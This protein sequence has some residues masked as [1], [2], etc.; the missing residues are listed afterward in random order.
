MNQLPIFLH[1]DDPIDQ[2]QAHAAVSSAARYRAILDGQSELIS[3][4][5]VDGR[6]T[7]VNEAYAHH[8]G[9]TPAQMIGTNLFD[10]VAESDRAAVQAHLQRVVANGAPAI[11]ENRMTF[12]NG[13]VHWVAWSNGVLLDD[14]GITPLIHSVGRDVTA[15]VQAQEAQ[16]HLTR[17][18]AE[19][20]E[21]LRVTLHS[22]GDAVI[23][24]DQAGL[25]DYMNPIAERLT[26]WRLGE[27]SGQPLEQVFRIVNESSRETVV[28]PVQRCMAENH[29]IGLAN[30][31]VLIARDGQEYGIEDSAAPMRNAE[32]QIIGAVLVFRD[33]TKQRLLAS[34]MRHRATHDALTGLINRTEFEVSLQRMLVE[35]QMQNVEHA[36]LYIDLDQFKLVNDACG[37]A[38]GDRLLRQVSGLLHQCARSRDTL[39]RLGGDEFG[40]ILE[41]CST[42]QAQRVATEVCARVEEFRFAHEGRRF[43]IG[44]SIGL[45]PI[46]ARWQ[47]GAAVLQAA[48]TA[49]YA[50]KEAGRNR[51]HTWF[52]TDK[53][54]QSR[55]GDMQWVRRLE[56]ALDDDQFVL[57]AQRI[58]PLQTAARELHC[59]VLLRLRDASGQLVA[60]GVFLPAAERFH[61]ASRIDRWVVRTVFELMARQRGHLDH[62][63]TLSVNLSGHS[64]GDRS[65]HAYVEELLV[66]TDVEAQRLC[67]EI[68]ET[69]AITN[70]GD[71][72]EFIEAMQRHGVRFALDDFGSGVSSFGSLKTL[73]VDYLK[74]DGQ[75][76][77]GLL[78]DPINQATVRCI[79]EVARAVGKQ[80][81]AEFVDREDE[82]ALLREIG[83]DY[84]QGYLLHRPAPLEQ[85]LGLKVEA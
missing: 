62:L 9:S 77:H 66:S 57:Y 53:A 69:A 43:R 19:Q 76:I 45:V 10:M 55:Q 34:E 70:L 36:L 49:C 59:E 15:R 35:A 47:N 29:T 78:T 23:T 81:I 79:R 26:G 68:T 24:I 71:A 60:P 48:D 72:L 30:H 51:V 46:D 25:I 38:A 56:Q 8:F 6:L 73:P 82:M 12:A 32:N 17:L 16:V 63:A 52:D 11:D 1:S 37:H 27:A 4:A 84:A 5:H 14:D 65:F 85:V 28:N 18:L 54:V 44:A 58:H 20:H 31:T 75:F 22:I 50:A 2:I 67:F 21:K 42:E 41:H 61:M 74:I 64:I 33:V 13:E 83:I 40:L 39:A 80:T 3:L 7:Y